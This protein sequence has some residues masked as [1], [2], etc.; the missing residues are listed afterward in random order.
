MRNKKA[1]PAI[2]DPGV[3][4][5]PGGVVIQQMRRSEQLESIRLEI[6][7]FLHQ[8]ESLLLQDDNDDTVGRDLHRI[9]GYLEQIEIIADELKRA[10]K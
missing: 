5:V 8:H 6:A 1:R 4:E 2:S 7:C 3:R 9:K 10:G